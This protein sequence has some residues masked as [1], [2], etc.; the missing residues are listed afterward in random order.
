M[1]IMSTRMRWP[2]A[3][4]GSAS[5][6]VLAA[7][8][9]ER[10]AEADTPVSEAEV[11]TELPESAVSDEQLQATANVAAD[12]AATPPPDIVAVPVQGGGTAAGGSAAAGAGSGAAGS[13]AATNTA[14]Q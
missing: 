3:A 14:G 4:V 9:S 2:L 10:S 1:K 5:L 11:T 6:I 12:M 13:T 8:D 7:C